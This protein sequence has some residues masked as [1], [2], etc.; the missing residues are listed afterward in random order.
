MKYDVFISYSS[1]D[2][3]VVEG[4]TAYLEQHNI[5]CF[6][7]YRDIPL[8][9]V[10]AKAI[11]EALEESRMML[12]VFSKDFNNS[13]QVDREIEIASED[14]KPIL[15]FR[16]A[17]DTFKGAKKYYLK[18][19]NW[20]DAF[21]NPE[22]HFSHV[23]KNVQK[24][25]GGESVTT[26]T[27]KGLNI[28][29]MVGQLKK[30]M[31]IPF[32]MLIII[33]FVTL[34]LPQYKT[35]KEVYQVGDYYNDKGVQGVVFEVWDDGEHGKILNLHQVVRTWDEAVNYCNLL[36][37]EWILPS[38]SDLVHINKNMT[39]INDCLLSIDRDLIDWALYWSSAEDDVG[40]KAGV[41]YMGGGSTAYHD[42]AKEYN[43][44][45]IATF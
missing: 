1:H 37:E 32:L 42:K 44:R 5:R 2:Q 16:I 7:A 24:L 10:W 29:K 36:G 17:D 27:H 22:K 21:P 45:A 31:L 38:K 26:N 8:G 12:V 30:Y 6:V 15:T 35:N 11:V 3:K 40:V 13:G 9:E 28:H 39:I 14:K 43:V 25:I 23:E 4:L 33:A 20:I 34:I 19:I 41:I 18:N